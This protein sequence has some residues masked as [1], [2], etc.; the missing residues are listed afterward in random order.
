VVG[1]AEEEVD[2]EPLL[3]PAM[4][5]GE[6]IHEETLEQ[7]RERTRRSLDSLPLALRS[8]GEKPRYPVRQS[9]GLAAAA[10]ALAPS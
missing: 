5:A 3:V 4:K 10:R 1:T 9:D 8:P 7:M 2:G 6:I